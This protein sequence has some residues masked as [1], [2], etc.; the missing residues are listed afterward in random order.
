MGGVRIRPC[1]V[2]AMGAGGEAIGLS[3]SQGTGALQGQV[4][5]M[6]TSSPR[7]TST[8]PSEVMLKPPV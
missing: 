3:Q 5:F 1:A 2:L 6:L 4:A 7:A 8:P